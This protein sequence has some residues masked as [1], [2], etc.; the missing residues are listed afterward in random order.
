M[1][2]YG[3]GI[4]IGSTSTEAV[5]VDADGRV[6][7][8]REVLTAPG[9][10]ALAAAL[11]AEL[12]AELPENSR[13]VRR[14]EPRDD[15]RGESH[16]VPSGESRKDLHGE[17]RDDAPGKLRQDAWGAAGNSAVPEPAVV[18]TG[19]GRRNVHGARRTVTEISCHARA[20]AACFP[21]ARGVIDIGGQDS[22]VIRLD[23]EGRVEDFLM[24]DKCAAGTGKFLQVMAQTL[25]LELEELGPRSLGTDAV[26]QITSTCTVFA[27]SEVISLLAAGE[28][29]PT[30]AASIHRAMARRVAGMVRQLRLAGPLVF[31][32]GV[33]RNPG[34]VRALEG[35]L[36]RTL[37]VPDHP[38]IMGAWGAALMAL[39]E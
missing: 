3:C 21:G 19:Y 33:A 25:H 8:W 28:D 14:G 22:K 27:E 13:E 10:A 18:G 12:R 30:L 20:A 6:I 34:M 35:V 23:A 16:E 7:A 5:L 38:Q 24:N 36:D 2:H 32:G 11:L 39:E 29:V 26:R 4:D 17:S 37:R 1:M 9:Q 15:V 31:T